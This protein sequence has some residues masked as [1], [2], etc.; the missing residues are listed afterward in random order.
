VTGFARWQQRACG[1]KRGSLLQVLDLDGQEA[2]PCGLA[3]LTVKALAAGG[4]E[5]ALVMW[6]LTSVRL[7]DA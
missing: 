5:G 4:D 7:P 3:I 1:R 2:K 6:P